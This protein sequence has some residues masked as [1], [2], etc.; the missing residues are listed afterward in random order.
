MLGAAQDKKPLILDLRYVNDHLF[1]NKIKF[2]NWS[3]FQNYLEGNKAYLFKF[4]L[5]SR[6]YHVDIFDEH[7]T[8][9]ALAEKLI[10]KHI[11]L[12]L[13]SYLLD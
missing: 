2:D 13:L 9:L 6:Y 4:N 11:I 10:N 1:N 7:Q 12:S 5:K 8:F 3:S